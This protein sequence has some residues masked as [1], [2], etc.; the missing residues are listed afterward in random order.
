MNWSRLQIGCRISVQLVLVISL[1]AVTCFQFLKLK[2]EITNVSISYN[3]KQDLEL[4]SITICPYYVK[5]EQNK[6]TTFE[7]YTKHILNVSDF[8]KIAGQYVYLP[9]ER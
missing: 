2:K 3:G 5:I 1:L 4:P 8:F 9:G 6:N 7:E